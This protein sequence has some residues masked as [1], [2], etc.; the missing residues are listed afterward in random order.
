MKENFDI[1]KEEFL[2]NEEYFVEK[3]E[4]GE[5]VSV[6]KPVDF[7][8]FPNAVKLDEHQKE[9]PGEELQNNSD[10]KPIIPDYLIDK[11]NIIGY[12]PNG[13]PIF[14]Q[15][16]L[17]EM[18]RKKEEN[19]IDK[20]WW[21][22]QRKNDELK[23][24]KSKRHIFLILKNQYIE[25]CYNKQWS[26]GNISNYA[27]AIKENNN[28]SLIHSFDPRGN[29]YYEINFFL[30]ERIN[31]SCPR[32]TKHLNSEIK[33]TNGKGFINLNKVKDIDG[34]RETIKERK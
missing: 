12:T 13:Q 32:K 25:G 21:V 14:K 16:D 26:G 7:D 6:K 2:H 10:V 20:I 4:K 30:S 22:Y 3:N 15:E 1:N 28:F 31:S 9:G 18:Y 17:G 23:K 27:L 33:L 8:Q 19:P 24:D 29:N 34:L 5:M 11:E